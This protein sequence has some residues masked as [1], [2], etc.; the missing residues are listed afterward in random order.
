MAFVIALLVALSVIALAIALRN[1][2]ASIREDDRAFLDPLPP[3]L[4]LIWPLVNLLTQHLG[5]YI[6]VEQVEQ[7]RL[8]MR[9]A[10]M[11]YLMTPVQMISLRFVAAGIFI[12]LM[13]LCLLMLDRFE[14]LWV[15]LAGLLGWMFPLMKV[16][17]LRKLREK[18]IVRALPMFL[19]FITM[20]VE[21]GMNLSGALQQAVEKGPE[22]PLR[23]ELQK[24]LRDVKAGM[25][26][27]EAIRAMSERLDI[28]E[29]HSFTSALAQAERTGASLGQTLR[30]QADQRRTE[31][32]QRAEKLALEAPVKLVFPLVAFI[33]PTTF[34]VLGFPIFMK[35]LYEV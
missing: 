1:I 9:K 20:A 26:R 5:D 25:S 33:F 15:L 31:R 7:T 11:E 28:R 6:P 21:A 35:F 12:V 22:G 13:V 32:F 23:V 8:K 27:M 24:V 2:R 16:N 14:P 4:R 18:K 29:I 19:D 3:A 10:G 17:D 34:I 30:I